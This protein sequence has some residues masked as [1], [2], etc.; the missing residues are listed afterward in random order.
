M[1]YGRTWS[2]SLPLFLSHYSRRE[3]MR[4][5]EKCLELHMT[6]SLK[7]NIRVSTSLY[8]KVHFSPQPPKPDLEKQAGGCGS[9][10]GFLSHLGAAFGTVLSIVYTQNPHLSLLQ[11][12][13]LLMEESSGKCTQPCLICTFIYCFT[14]F[15]SKLS[16]TQ[17]ISIGHTDSILLFLNPCMI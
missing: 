8:G 5:K 12:S 1:N 14:L 11:H 10:Q 16:T 7:V 17:S 15:I 6:C 3:E 13:Q 4:F 2:S 9:R